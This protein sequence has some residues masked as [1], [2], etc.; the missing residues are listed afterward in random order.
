M[1]GRGRTPWFTLDRWQWEG[2]RPEG[3]PC[4]AEAASP[5]LPPLPLPQY[6]AQGPVRRPVGVLTSPNTWS[7]VIQIV[8]LHRELHRRGLPGEAV[9]AFLDASPR[10]ELSVWHSGHEHGRARC[11]VWLALDDGTADVSN[12]LQAINVNAG[13][14]LASATTGLVACRS[15]EWTRVL[16]QLSGY[17]KGCR[18]AFVILKGEGNT[19]VLE[20]NVGCW[21]AKFAAPTLR[22][23]PVDE[24]AD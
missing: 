11:E 6:A 16:L 5:P 4:C 21:G 18:R 9:A 22:L 3:L 23:V 7:S 20:D 24:L 17:P 10:L 2:S 1:P 12:W 13:H 14:H 8:D 19:A 15:A